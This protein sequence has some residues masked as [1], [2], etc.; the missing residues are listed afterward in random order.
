MAA[1]NRFARVRGVS[2]QGGTKPASP[3]RAYSTRPAGISEGGTSAQ[4]TAASCPKRSTT[5]PD[6]SESRHAVAVPGEGGSHSEDS[7]Q[8]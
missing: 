3:L 2:R 4:F 5:F 6:V 1:W 7:H 8:S